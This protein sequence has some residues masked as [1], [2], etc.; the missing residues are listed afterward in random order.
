MFRRAPP[1]NQS[2]LLSGNIGR[3]LGLPPIQSLFVDR[4]VLA[5]FVSSGITVWGEELLPL[6]PVEPIRRWDVVLAFFGLASQAL[7]ILTIYPFI[8]GGTRYAMGTLKRSIHNCFF[9]Y[10]L[11]R[12]TLEEEVSFFQRRL[13]ANRELTQLLDLRRRFRKSFSFVLFCLPTLLRL[14]LRTLIENRFPKQSN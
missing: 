12:A 2:D 7:L 1:E 10:E 3:I 8:P 5:N 9:C 4:V 11:R 14:H 13:G 6:I